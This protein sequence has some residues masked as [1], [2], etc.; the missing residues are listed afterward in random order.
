MF[1]I[2][3]FVKFIKFGVTIQ[4]YIIKYCM[5]ICT[6]TYVHSGLVSQSGLAY[7]FVPIRQ[8][9]VV[10]QQKVPNEIS[11][12][13]NSYHSNHTFMAKHNIHLSDKYE[14]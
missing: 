10:G 1:Y 6:L 12:L 14:K 2:K 3:P 8:Q 7:R 4:F 5:K 11:N 13:N 9:L